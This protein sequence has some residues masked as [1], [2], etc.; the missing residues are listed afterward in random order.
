[1]ATAIGKMPTAAATAPTMIRRDLGMQEPLKFLEESRESKRLT[2][3]A[4]RWFRPGGE[5]AEYGRE[6]QA[7]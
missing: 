4:Y 6:D 2:V 5:D 7:A 3:Q 1:L